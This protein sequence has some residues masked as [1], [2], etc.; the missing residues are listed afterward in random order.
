MNQTFS[1]APLKLKRRIEDAPWKSASQRLDCVCEAEADFISKLAS[2]ST[3]ANCASESGIAGQRFTE[4]F[5]ALPA[6]NVGTLAALI[7]IDA[8]VWGLRPWRAAR[9][10]VVNVPKPT[11]TTGSLFLSESVMASIIAS[12]TRPAVAFGISAPAATASINS[13]LFTLSPYFSMMNNY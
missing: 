13:D 1:S 5:S 12:I 9:S 6:L 2:A 11:S 7:W 8:P 10:L 3:S 4:S